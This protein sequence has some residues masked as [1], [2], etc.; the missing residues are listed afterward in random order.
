MYM[1]TFALFVYYKFLQQLNLRSEAVK[2]YCTEVNKN[3]IMFYNV[4]CF[5]F[6]S[7][8]SVP[9]LGF[10]DEP[11]HLSNSQE[12]LQHAQEIVVS[13]NERLRATGR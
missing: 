4:S 11:Y 6:H 9:K 8:V 3:V 10:E 12:C 7:H 13:S 2:K 1:Y 5:V